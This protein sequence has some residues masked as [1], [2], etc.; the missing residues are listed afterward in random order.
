LNRGGVRLGTAEIYTV[1][2]DR[3][4]IADSLVVHLDTPDF[5]DRLVLFVVAP[6]GLSPALRERIV[7]DLRG[8]LSPRHVPDEIV[9]V[10][11]VPRTL[12]GK[13]LEI[14]VKRV[15]LGADPAEVANPDSLQDPTAF[16]EYVAF[17]R[18]GP[19][20]ASPGS[21]GGTG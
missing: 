5:L 1:V 19:D 4:E 21:V 20:A 17:A 8:L 7:R 16:A 18:S 11:V 14:P 3:P 13:K 12:S 15:L 9:A 2:E 10:R 6:G